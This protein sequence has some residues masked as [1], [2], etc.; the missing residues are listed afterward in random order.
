M[1]KRTT[2]STTPKAA[3]VSDTADKY[4]ALVNPVPDQATDRG[5]PDAIRRSASDPSEDDIRVRA[6][7]RYLERGGS[8]GHDVDDWIQAEKEL[9]TGV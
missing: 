9:K 5:V 3:R 1:A 7:R 6:Y 2:R 4:A 8:H